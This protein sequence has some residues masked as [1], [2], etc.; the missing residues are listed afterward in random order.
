MTATSRLFCPSALAR[1]GT[2][3]LVLATASPAKA[4]LI[5]QQSNLVSD[6]PGLA[7]ITDPLL[8]NPWGMSFSATSPIWVSNEGTGASTLYNISGTTG[9]ITQNPLVVTI[10]GPPT[11]QVFNGGSGFEVEPGRPARFL[12]AG[13]DGTISGWN[14]GANLT[15]ALKKVDNSA[16]GAVYTGLALGSNASGQFLFGA[17]FTGGSIDVFDSTFAPAS[18]A[19]SFT[20][21]TLPAGYA[22][23]NI[24]NIGGNLYVA[25]AELG[26]GGDEET[27]IGK[28]LVSVFDTNGNFVRR[29]ATGSD[30]GGSL[31]EL[32]APW[33]FALAPS[34]FGVL[35]NALLVGNFGDGHIN[36][37][38]PATDAFLGQMLASNGSPVEIEGLWGIAFGNGGNGGIHNRLYFAAG[39][40]DEQHGLF[41]SLQVIPEPGALSLLSAALLPGV[42]LLRRRRK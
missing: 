6:I 33:G 31:G 24:Q 13:L 19:G 4:Q 20:D 22:P 14:P 34:D 2:L 17:N 41:G 9:K 30:A 15:N 10:P 18:L 29:L 32:N 21:P 11:G 42:A 3:L 23:F 35:S 28:G 7:Q 38:D 12:F 27:G 16:F 25:Y 39:I 5:Y 1:A 36:A 40:D 26:P 37:F 8:I